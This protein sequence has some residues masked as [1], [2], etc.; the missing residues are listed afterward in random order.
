M[1]A[2]YEII[3]SQ[4]PIFVGIGL[5]DALT[6]I[7]FKEAFHLRREVHVS[8]PCYSFRVL[9]DDILSCDFY[10]DP[11]DVDALAFVVNVGLFQATALSPPHPGGNNQLVVGFILAALVAER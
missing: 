1:L 2:E 7:L 5:P 6:I 4:L 8:I 9:D 10:H 3:S 11:L